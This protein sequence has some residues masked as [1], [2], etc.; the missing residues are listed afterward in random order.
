[1]NAIK[2]DSGV[3]FIQA[4][5]GD[6]MPSGKKFR[7]VAYTGA[8]IR[9]GWSREPVVIDMAG[10]QLPA[11]V[12]VVVGHDY[13]LGSI[14]GQGRPFIEAGQIIVEGEILA[15]NE[16]ARQV[17]ALGAAGYQFQAS[18]GAD[19]RRHQKIDAE[20]VTTV[21]GTAHIGPVRVVK[22]SA[23]REVSFVT[24]GADAAT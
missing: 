23:L 16:N 4:A 14:V 1:M 11:T 20:G 15:D 10:M 12:P 24:L 6:S 21:N 2:L 18:V 5:E 9:Q 7:I 22:A 19:V 17:A 13:A 3:E 8:Q